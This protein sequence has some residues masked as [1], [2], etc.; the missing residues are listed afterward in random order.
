MFVV[1]DIC[2]Y[3]LRY[4]SD[5][6]AK[7]FENCI[8]YHINDPDVRVALYSDGIDE[9]DYSERLYNIIKPEYD[10]AKKCGFQEW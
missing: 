10:F 3:Q 8:K 9:D 6:V 1:G 7:E 4:K 2:A 5:L